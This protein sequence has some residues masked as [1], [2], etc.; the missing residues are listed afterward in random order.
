MDALYAESSSVNG[1]MVDVSNGSSVEAQGMLVDGWSAVKCSIVV[2]GWVAVIFT[3]FLLLLHKM[4][5]Y[6]W[7]DE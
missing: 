5:L 6:I 3:V 7:K 4:I 1:G 2:S